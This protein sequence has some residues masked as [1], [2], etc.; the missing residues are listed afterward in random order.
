MS[1]ENPSC[2]EFILWA[3]RDIRL[4]KQR[5]GRSPSASLA[6][7]FKVVCREFEVEAF[8]STL[9]Q[10]IDDGTI[11]LTARSCNITPENLLEPRS[12][13]KIL[14]IPAGAPLD[15]H[16]WYIGQDGTDMSG[17]KAERYKLYEEIQLYIV[18]DGLPAVLTKSAQKS[19]KLMGLSSLRK[20]TAA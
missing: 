6:D 12:L 15:Q 9:Q 1:I 16:T 4:T 2:T 8:R 5:H 11:V 14:R 3:I 17:K 10:R 18:A 7:A 19:Q 20:Q 13:Q